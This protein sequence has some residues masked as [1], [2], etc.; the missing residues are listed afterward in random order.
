MTGEVS[1]LPLLLNTLVP[2]GNDLPQRVALVGSQFRRQTSQQFGLVLQDG[3]G[4][5]HCLRVRHYLAPALSRKQDP[6]L[7]P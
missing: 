5:L 2:R 6:R 4:A 3:V 7:A 1:R